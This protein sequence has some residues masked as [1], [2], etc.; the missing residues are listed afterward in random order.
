MNSSPLAEPHIEHQ[1]RADDAGTTSISHS[2]RV[3]VGLTTLAALA[4]ASRS[5]LAG[6]P[7]PVDTAA[8][9]DPS[10]VLVKLIGR[11]T[12]G[13]TI[14]QLS[15]AQS[16]GYSGYLEH[17][18]N[19]TALDDS[20]VEARVADPIRLPM[21]PRT[22]VNDFGPDLLIPLLIE[23]TILR[24]IF[25]PRQLF[26]RM[27]EFWS[28]H[29]SIYVVDDE[30]HVLKTI[31]DRDVIRP[32]ALGLF[33]D[34]LQR[35]AKSPAM[36]AYLNGQQN[37]AGLP[38]ENYAR[39]LME[40]HTMGASG[41][42]TQ[43]D[44]AEVA[45]CFTGWGYVPWTPGTDFTY[46]TFRFRAEQHDNGQKT[47]LGNIIPAGGGI[48]DGLRV[49]QILTEHPSTAAFIARKLCIRFL[50]DNPPQG[51]VDTVAATYT[52]TG[53]DIK[54]ML[55]KVLHPDLIHQA[56]PKLKRP[57]H[58]VASAVRALNIGV[59]SPTPLRYWL[60]TS[61]H[62]VF[63]WGPPSGYPDTFDFWAGSLLPRWNWG[64]TFGSNSLQDLTFDTAAFFAGATAPSAAA[65][66]IDARLFM[67]GMNPGDKAAIKTYLATNVLNTFTYRSAVGLAL[68]SPGFQVY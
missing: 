41:G 42:F 40:L 28:D 36:L 43:Q 67:G 20:A 52:A 8:D 26:E 63:H 61:G 23:A 37:V 32:N 17:H 3:V 53:G 60:D 68:A 29:F 54:A 22:L 58:F 21:V 33:P 2:R 46:G 66:R 5:A 51:A 16:L 7:A 24:A 48:D 47:V 64:G 18:L 14:E 31:D 35:V 56:P 6:P 49:L 4:Q 45:R 59:N 30:Q 10:A 55:R 34:L 65:D 50:G 9:V 62:Q 44:V 39:E 27:V 19:H 1:P 13:P 15:L 11:I 38:N 25:S 12:F 57:F